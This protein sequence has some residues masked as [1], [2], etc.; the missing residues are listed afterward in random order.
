[1]ADKSYWFTTHWP[2]RVD[3]DDIHHRNIYL[4]AGKEHVGARI[5]AGDEVMIYESRTG[6]A[7]VI[8]DA[9]GG[10]RVVKRKLGRMGAATVAE[11]AGQLEERPVDERVEHYASGRTRNW[12]WTA[13]TH[14]HF[15]NGFVPLK[16][17]LRTLDLS[18][19]YNMFGFG[20]AN[21]GLRQIEPWQFDELLHIFRSNPT[22]KPIAP[23]G[24]R[25]KPGHPTEAG[26]EGDDHLL[27][28]QYV[29][30][31]PAAVLGEKGVE[32]IGSEFKFGT[33]DSADVALRDRVGRVIGVEIEIAQR[34]PELEGILQAIKYRHML[35]VMFR[36]RFDE[37]RAVLVAYELD[38]WVKALCD[39]YDV[40][41]A[42]V[43]RREVS[44][45][46]QNN[47]RTPAG[48]NS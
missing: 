22:R 2:H 25:T 18:P 15:S 23:G 17:V 1:V 6:D 33:G 34:K 20:D 4:Q 45:W 42:E 32:T 27:L 5:R 35:A 36:Q 12:K 8:A 43:E 38:A 46:A 28:K 16:D 24:R 40:Q 19:N 41:W 29:A 13:P 44:A 39:E 9:H 3:Q 7:I 31:N 14:A 30:A 10:T 21:S 26:G 37:S 47:S 48:V 11:V